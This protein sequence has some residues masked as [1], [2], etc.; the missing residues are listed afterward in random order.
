MSLCLKHV[1][2]HAGLFTLDAVSLTVASGEHVVL[3][4]TTGS[5]KTLLLETICGLRKPTSG[6]I[7]SNGRELTF[8]S[9]GERGL[10]YVP[11]DGALFQS[12]R[13]RDQLAFPLHIRGERAEAKQRVEAV[14][15]LVG[16]ESLLNRTPVGL[17]GGERQRISL[18]RA[19]VFRPKVLLLDEPLS[20]LD[21]ETR[22][23]LLP[24][25]AEVRAATGVTILHVTHSQ[26][27]A[28]EL[29]DRVLFMRELSA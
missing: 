4:G 26:R 28:A 22:D 15:S 7:S 1:C 8:L 3:M 9:P 13:V 18:A 10:G 20:A 19:I 25:F 2:L 12:M 17:S 14:A 29:G 11:Q 5:G 23:A 21:D 24:V 6:S 27:E 16:I